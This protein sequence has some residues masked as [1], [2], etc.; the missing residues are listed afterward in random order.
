MTR[1][2]REAFTLIELLVVVSII[3]LRVAILLPALSRARISAL[4]SQCRSKLRQ[5]VIAATGPATDF[6]SK[7]PTRGDLLSNQIYPCWAPHRQWHPLGKGTYADARFMR[8]DY[9][10]NAIADWCWQGNEPLPENLEAP[11]DRSIW[12]HVTIGLIGERWRLVPT[13]CWAGVGFRRRDTTPSP[14]QYTP[15]H[16][17]R[18]SRW[19]G[20]A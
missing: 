18:S 16:T 8:V 10:A 5:M 19:L 17:R 4:E 1:Q 14:G 7:F 11:L 9:L 15:R 13:P 2:T 20:S 6:K 12:T 3:A